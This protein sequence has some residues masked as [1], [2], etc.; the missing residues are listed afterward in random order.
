MEMAL[1]LKSTAIG[2]VIAAPVGPMALLCMQ[3]TLRDGA[4]AG[5]PFGLG[6]A[7]ADAT[8]AAVAGFG[9]SAIT[10][11]LLSAAG[12][13]QLVGGLVLIVL[14]LHIAR[15]RPS[16]E[17]KATTTSA[18]GFLTAYGLTLAN[19]PTIL[20]FA[21]VFASLSALPSADEALTFTTGV[22]VGSLAWWMAL[23][24]VVLRLART[25]SPGRLVWLNRVSGL[26][27][28]AIGGWALWSALA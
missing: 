7:A 16:R 27:L 23:T 1:F 18:A 12:P 17:A 8:Y 22:F 20:S 28:A 13:L 3:R 25:L 4:A 14:G 2:V 9:L 15:S 21:A 24:F 19:P 26:A 10:Q 11:V 5:L 6:I